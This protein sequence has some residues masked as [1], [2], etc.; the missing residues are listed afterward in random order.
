M[1][2]RYLALIISI[3]IL[4]CLPLIFYVSNFYSVEISENPGDWGTFGDYL[5]GLLNPYIS[6]L[7]LLVTSYIAYILFKYENIRDKQSK[8]EA[9]VKS[10]ME[11]YQFFI[12]N[13]FREARTTA[14]DILKKAIA[15]DSYRDF[16]VRENYV[17]RYIN[18]KPRPDV[19]SE[20]A[21][22]LYPKEEQLEQLKQAAFLKREAMDRN[23]ID[24][25]INFFQLL[26]LKDVP[27]DYYKVCDFYYDT[28]RP[29]LYWYATELKAAYDKLAEN[30]KYNNPPTLL[31]A[32][33][34]LDNRFYAPEVLKELTKAG[35][36][37]HPIIVHMKSKLP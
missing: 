22:I 27:E 25:I 20:F 18:R 33:T 17:S 1:K 4:G 30:K 2:G 32:L 24:V 9:D 11:L 26:S 36:K 29:V 19:Y 16:V 15:N 6:L 14:W 13:E 34:K 5:G 31:E 10:F 12:S 28:W 23:K 37:K 35:Y 21:E 8:H 3:F 7:T